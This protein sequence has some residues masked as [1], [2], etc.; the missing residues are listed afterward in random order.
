MAPIPVSTTLWGVENPIFHDCRVVK[1]QDFPLTPVVRDQLVSI[2]FWEI[3]L[4]SFC[5]VEPP[6]APQ[7]FMDSSLPQLIAGQAVLRC[8]NPLSV[9]RWA[10]P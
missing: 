9:A 1:L 10:L 3:R 4:R 5:S 2:P 6:P 8:S 7:R